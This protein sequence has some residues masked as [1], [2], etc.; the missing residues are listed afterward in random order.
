M[1]ELRY[2]NDHACIL[3][4]EELLL[5]AWYQQPADAEFR[6]LARAVSTVLRDVPERHAALLIAKHTSAPKLE[7]ETRRR[8]VYALSTHATRV[9]TAVVI[10]EGGLLGSAAR[11]ALTAALP[12]PSAH[13]RVFPALPAATGWLA[14]QLASGWSPERIEGV[15]RD[16]LRRT[17]RRP[18]P[19]L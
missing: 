8:L 13:T 10:P 7:Q 12:P 17:R 19:L 11:S 16:A 6:A 2:Q 3:S 14:Q 9:R 15:Y 1:I 4:D 5:F 18:A